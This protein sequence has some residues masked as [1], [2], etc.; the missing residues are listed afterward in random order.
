MSDQAPPQAS[1]AAI[2]SLERAF[3]DVHD[4]RDD[5]GEQLRSAICAFTSMMKSEG[6]TAE[7]V[8]IAVKQTAAREG[9]AWR[10]RSQLRREQSSDVT[11][12]LSQA[13]R[14]CIDHYYASEPPPTGTS[15]RR[16][17]QP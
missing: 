17:T 1:P 12:I 3:A 15:A 16:R 7:H 4:E 8:I 10:S 6:W 13:V 5:D 14:W 2:A 11:E 9:V